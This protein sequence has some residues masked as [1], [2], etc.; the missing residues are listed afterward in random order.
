MTATVRAVG[1]K[2]AGTTSAV[3]VAEPAGIA[4]GDLE[5]LLASAAE[6]TTVSITSNGGGA[7][8]AMYA[9]FPMMS[10][11]TGGG[12]LCGWYRIRAGGDSDPQVTANADCVVACRIAITTGTFDAG[13]PFETLLNGHPVTGSESTS[14][15][16]VSFSPQ[17][18]GL[19]TTVN[20]CLC[21]AAGTSG[22]DSDTPQG[23]TNTANSSLSSVTATPIAN[24][25]T[26]NGSGAGFWV[27][28]G[29]KATAGAQG[30]WTQ[31]MVG[32]TAKAFAAWV[33]RPSTGVVQ[34]AALTSSGASASTFAAKTRR[35]AAFTS[36]ASSATTLAAS[37]RRKAVATSAA[38][39]TSAFNAEKVTHAID[40]SF[41][42][43]GN[44]LSQFDGELFNA[45]KRNADFASDAH[46]T[47]AFVASVRRR[48]PASLASAATSTS[49]FW[50]IR[51]GKQPGAWTSSTIS[52]SRFNAEGIIH[53]AQVTAVSVPIQPAG[54]LGCGQPAAEVWTRG[55]GR[56]VLALPG[57]TDV[58]WSRVLGDTSS[59]DVT[60]AGQTVTNDPA[61]CEVLREIRPWKH[62]LHIYR[63]NELQW[64]GPIVEMSTSGDAV[65]LKARDVSAWLDHRF[66]HG[67]H[68][69]GGQGAG[70]GDTDTTTIFTDLVTDALA[71]DPSP[72]IDLDFGLTSGV[73]AQGNYTAASFKAVGPLIRELAKGSIDWYAIMRTLRYTGGGV[74]TPRVMPDGAVDVTALCVANPDFEVNASNWTIARDS[75]VLGPAGTW[76]FARDLTQFKNGVASGKASFS[77]SMPSLP[78]LTQPLASLVVGKTYTA[79]VW[80]RAGTRIASWYGWSGYGLHLRVADKQSSDIAYVVCS[81][82][83]T[84][85]QMTVTFKATATTHSLEVNCFSGCGG[86]PVLPLSDF[87]VDAV[88]L[89]L[90][91]PDAAPFVEIPSAP[92]AIPSLSLTDES[93]AVVPTVMLAGLSQENRSVVSAQQSGGDVAF[94]G[95]AP[96][97]VWT[98]GTNGPGLTPAQEEYGLLETA[99]TAPVS[100]SSGASAR[101]S[102]RNAQLTNTPVVLTSLALGPGAGVTMDQLVPGSLI[103]IRLDRICLAV[104]QV[105]MLRQVD[106]KASGGGEQVTLTVEP[107]GGAS[108]E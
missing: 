8:T 82:P 52:T 104:N 26:S 87:Y 5:I 59:G 41:T 63:D 17:G 25:Q 27:A 1:A 11:V 80:V 24:Y 69:Y 33:V 99:I 72:N 49:M 7:W 32:S 10:S 46:S 60:L 107:A 54:R 98:M 40:A 30:T 74:S 23:G 34:D 35:G 45:T 14:D 31:T 71:P 88:Q 65:T 55:G 95:E 108:A 18:A 36:A 53:Y 42:S 2:S 51:K 28:T 29:V 93:L 67:S 78:K 4:T 58:N 77:T 73:W 21:W 39:S 38:T 12:G 56:L 96:Q 48:W 81:N 19:N 9:G 86:Y 84:W 102:Q 16:S 66:V 57:I 76:S 92:A 61:C 64:C 94:Y 103:G 22:A 89:V 15:T 20:D 44:S 47:S 37:V 79:S 68:I 3:T 50:P 100:D 13:Q 6:T 62:E 91:D 75:H 70:Q 83:T 97:P 106:V 85:Y 105:M 90:N 101:A 43:I